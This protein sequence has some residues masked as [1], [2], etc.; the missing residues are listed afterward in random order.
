M[1]SQSYLFFP[2]KAYN[3]HP[4]SRWCCNQ[5]FCALPWS[6][7][8]HK[9]QWSLDALFRGV[10]DG[11]CWNHGTEHRSVYIVFFHLSQTSPNK[12]TVE[13]PLVFNTALAPPDQIKILLTECI[14]HR[15]AG[16]VFI[17]MAGNEKYAVKIAPWKDE[18]QMLQQEAGIYE[19]LSDLQGWCIPEI[20]GFFSSDH[21]ET[22]IMAYMG[23]T[24]ENVSDLNTDQRCTVSSL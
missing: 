20:Y 12:Q 15:G 18:K 6:Q 1:R 24:V 5:V 23:C 21:L 17:G 4:Y 10:S 19:V 14:G 3:P 13:D 22:L 7:Y 9:I 2:E 8:L 16:Q 11:P